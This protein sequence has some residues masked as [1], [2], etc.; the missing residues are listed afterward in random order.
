MF[1]YAV[2][3]GRKTGIYN[4]W[5]DCLA[6]VDK[7]S[8]AVYKKFKSKEDA[9]NFIINYKITNKP[10]KE[11]YNYT[12][13]SIFIFVDG[14]FNDKTKMAG[15]GYVIVYNDE[16]IFKKAGKTKEFNDMKN[17]AGELKSV[18]SCLD[19]VKNKMNIIPYNKIKYINIVYDYAGISNFV[20]GSY[21]TKKYG[22]EI[23]KT[24]FLKYQTFFESKK[25]KI[26][27][28]KV[29]GHSGDKYNNLAD[30]L[31]KKEIF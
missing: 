22:S 31:A 13:N 25:I 9:N 28:I 12:D 24:T 30:S 2:A 29:K 6:Q 11:K 16:I 7:Y 1:Y 20:N 8:G 15:Y 19:Y 14:S 4:N 10:K 27:F 17:V 3:V 5:N 18:I 21:N 23:Y 26:K